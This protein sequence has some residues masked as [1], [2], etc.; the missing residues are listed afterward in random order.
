MTLNSIKTLISKVMNIVLKYLPEAQ[1]NELFFLSDLFKGFNEDQIRDFSSIYRSRRKDPNIILIT[2]LLG[3]V[4]VAGVHRFITEQIGLGILYFF[5]GGLCLI[6][7]IV[8]LVNYQNLAFEYNR[9][10]AHEVAAIVSR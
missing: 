9:R 2:A 4:G 7:T 3:F 10:V 1:G 5:T 8:D 6:G